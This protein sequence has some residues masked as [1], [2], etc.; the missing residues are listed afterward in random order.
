MGAESRTGTRSRNGDG[1]MAGPAAVLAAKAALVVATDKRTWKSAGVMLATALV[2]VILVLVLILGMA[3]GTAHHNNTAVKLAFNGGFLPLTMPGEYREYITEMRDCFSALDHAV[4]AVGRE[5]EW[6][7]ELDMTRVKAVFYALF[8]G[9]NDLSL[10]RSEARAFLDCFISYEERARDCGDADCED[11]PCEE[12]TVAIPIADLPAV[13]SNVGA[14]IGRAITPEDMA[15]ISEIYLRVGRGD[16]TVD[17]GAVSLE[18][19]SNGTHALIAD[20]TAND[21]SPA[22]N[23]GYTPPIDNW[24]GIVSCEYGT[25]YEGHTGMDL[26][27]PEGTPIKAVADGT[28]LFTRAS[29][30]GYGIHVAINHGGQVVTLY[31]HCSRLLVG[32]GQRVSQGEVIALSGDTGNSTGPHLHLEFVIDGQ[33]YNP[34]NYLN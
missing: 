30:T 17:S 10:R 21:D 20:L 11:D 2:P 19:G 15:N 13:Y 27:I 23:R 1:L 4:E 5:N 6:E 22:P 9:E 8:F 29:S 14:H 34:R 28:V 12:Y 18:G 25:G 33:Y 16:F 31:A 32:E 7:G 3:N 26:A 24:R